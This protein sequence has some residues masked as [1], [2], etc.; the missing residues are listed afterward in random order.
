ML[1]EKRQFESLDRLSTHVLHDIK[2]HVSGLSLVVENA[3]RHLGNPEF[4]RD[5]LAVVERTVANLRQLMSQV[6]SVARAPEVRPE[7]C[8]VPALLS[9]AAASAGL[10]VAERD[11]IAFRMTCAVD[12]PVRLDR[13]QM[14]RVV[15]N[16]LTV[17]TS[18]TLDFSRWYA[19]RTG[20][21]AGLMLAI[22]VWGFRA[23]MGRRRILSA[24]MFRPF[25]T[26]KAGGLGI[27]LVQCRSIV[28]AHGGAI[29]VESR[30]TVGTTFTV[31]IPADARVAEGAGEVA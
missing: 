28:E 16:L 11:G 21:I 3:R 18:L 22:S 30:P 8:A 4:Q 23:V 20:V 15:S 7:P 25:A 12:H 6:A 24:A 10:T 17:C 13:G 31:R 14:L 9:E 27:G 26:T 1:A 2:N 19:W 29:M 5:A